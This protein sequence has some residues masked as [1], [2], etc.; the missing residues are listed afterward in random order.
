MKARHIFVFGNTIIYALLPLW[1]YGGKGGLVWWHFILYIPALLLLAYGM[2]R[3]FERFQPST[4]TLALLQ[5]G[6]VLHFIGG[7]SYADTRIYNMSIGFIRFDKIV[8]FLNAFIGTLALKDILKVY[9][10]PLRN[11]QI[12]FLTF[13]V[14]GFGGCIEILEYIGTHFVHGIAPE[15]LYDNNMRD[16]I[17]NF[18]GALLGALWSR[19]TL[20]ASAQK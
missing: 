11:L 12:F 3:L 15:N 5:I 14:L 9:L 8:H 19:H 17:A 4:T 1:T 6:L 20:S 16:L 7:L 10:T 2:H 18:L 13:I